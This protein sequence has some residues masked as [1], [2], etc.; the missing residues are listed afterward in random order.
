MDMSG[1]HKSGVEDEAPFSET[2]SMPTA[3]VAQPQGVGLLTHRTLDTDATSD[4]DGSSSSLSLGDDE[5]QSLVA[6]LSKAKDERLGGGKADGEAA[7]EAAGGASQPQAAGQG[8]GKRDGPPTGVAASGPVADARRV[9]SIPPL[10]S[11]PSTSSTNRT[12]PRASPSLG[13]SPLGTAPAAAA[14]SDPVSA[15]KVKDFVEGQLG[16]TTRAVQPEPSIGRFYGSK[17][18]SGLLQWKR[19]SMRN[20][21]RRIQGKM[22]SKRSHKLTAEAQK[23]RVAAELP[24]AVHMQIIEEAYPVVLKS[25]QY[26]IDQLG[27]KNTYTKQAILH[28][29]ILAARLNRKCDF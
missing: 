11:P 25:V 15:G 18:H 26:Y 9:T 7:G 22:Q 12:N 5:L 17:V 29:R 6:H 10:A 14:P 13:A 4:G 24:R 21:F 2:D 20:R 8:R 16:A 28:L 27:M 3:R 23:E 1:I 19:K